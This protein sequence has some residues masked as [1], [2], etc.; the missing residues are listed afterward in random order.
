MMVDGLV[1]WD[2]ERFRV[3]VAGLPAE[4]GRRTPLAGPALIPVI[5]P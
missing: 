2:G 1:A 5:E 3:L 4:D